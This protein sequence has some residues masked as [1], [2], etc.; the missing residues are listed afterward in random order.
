VPKRLQKRRRRA[1]VEPPR[2]TA[3]GVEPELWRRFLGQSAYRG[4]K[5]GTLMNL[6]LREWLARHEH[7]IDFE[8]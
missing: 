3:R 8:Q 5:V 6:V 4:M 1:E 2:I 7:E